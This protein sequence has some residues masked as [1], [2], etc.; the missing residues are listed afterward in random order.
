MAVVSERLSSAL[1]PGEEDCGSEVSQVQLDILA[2]GLEPQ[3]Q[4]VSAGGL[5]YAVE[6]GWIV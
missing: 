6:R 5:Q 4:E 2:P 3:E 1:G